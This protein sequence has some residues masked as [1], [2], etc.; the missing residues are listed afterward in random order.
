[1]AA[2]II[3]YH[4]CF[5]LIIY[6]YLLILFLIPSNISPLSCFYLNVIQTRICFTSKKGKRS[7]VFT[8]ILFFF[9]YITN[10]TPPEYLLFKLSFIVSRY[11]V[12]KPYFPILSLQTFPLCHCFFPTSFSSP[13]VILYLQPFPLSLYNILS[14]QPL[15]H[16]SLCHY[17]ISSLYVLLFSIL[18]PVSHYAILSSPPHSPL[19]HFF[20]QTL[21]SIFPYVI[22]SSPPFSPLSMSFTFFLLIVIFSFIGFCFRLDFIPCLS[23]LLF[24]FLSLHPQPCFP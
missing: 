10:F 16:F 21:L 15:P 22:L 3:R 6:L 4:K 1:M 14:L 5:F 11:K 18:F 20:S 24:S 8:F 13:Y 9:I 2:K 19:Y 17:F 12:S 23:F 7:T